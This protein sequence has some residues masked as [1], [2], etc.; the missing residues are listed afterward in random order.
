MLV[1]LPHVSNLFDSDIVVELQAE[2]FL[3]SGIVLESQWNG[4]VD[5]L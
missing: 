4:K 3:K 2:K 5:H 1:S